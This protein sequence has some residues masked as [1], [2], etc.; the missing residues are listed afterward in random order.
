[1]FYTGVNAKHFKILS[2]WAC[3]LAP[4]TAGLYFL[5]AVTTM[6]DMDASKIIFL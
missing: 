4:L 2:N 3:A 1:M 5:P 6:S